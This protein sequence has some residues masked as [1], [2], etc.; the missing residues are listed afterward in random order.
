MTVI[1]QEQETR[2]VDHTGPDIV[3]EL[4]AQI[5][6]L[7]DQDLR[8]LAQI[9]KRLT[10]P[11][12]L[13]GRLVI[14]AAARAGFAREDLDEMATAIAEAHEVPDEHAREVKFD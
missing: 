14:D 13:P 6:E 2:T 11:S 8:L 5:R 9:V 10:R 4:I 3:D 1:I 7:S 12:G